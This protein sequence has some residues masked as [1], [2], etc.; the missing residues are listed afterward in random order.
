MMIALKKNAREELRIERSEY[1]G[2]D[3]VT[4]RVWFRADDGEMKPGRQGIAFKSSMLRLV[5]DA[6]KRIEAGDE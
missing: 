3:V 2:H 5:A 4:I 1:R 6:L